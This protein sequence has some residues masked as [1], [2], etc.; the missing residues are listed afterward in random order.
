M[1]NFL[2]KIEKY[3][4]KIK[5]DGF[6]NATKKAFVKIYSDYLVKWDMRRQLYFL[7]NKKKI[8]E[9]L[10]IILKNNSFNRIIIWRSS[11]G[12][13]I[14]LFQRPQ[15]LAIELSKK[16]CLVFF[17]VTKLTDK[18][19]FY[20]KVDNNLYLVNF[21]I[22]K[23]SK[24]FHALIEKENISKYLFTASTCWDMSDKIV[25]NYVN[26]GY[27]FL[28]DYLDE[29]SPKLAGTDKLP[30]N[31]SKIYN[32]VIKNIDNCYVLCTADNLYNDIVS[33][34]KNNRNVLYVSNGVDYEHFT[35]IKKLPLSNDYQKML[36]NKK[37]IIGYYGALASWFDY[38]LIR[39][40]ALERPNYNIA[41]IGV[42]YDT[43]FDKQKINELPNVFYFGGKK[44]DELPYYAS[45]F[46]ICI[47]PFKI[48]EI[49][50]STNPIKIFEY[51]ALNKPIVSTKLTEC[52]K[53]QSVNIANNKK[54]FIELIDRY[55]INDDKKYKEKLLTDAKNNTWDSKAKCIIEG[56]SCFENNTPFSN[57][58]SMYKIFEKILLQNENIE[59][60]ENVL[61]KINSNKKTFIVTIN[62]EICMHAMKNMKYYDLIMGN[63]TLLIPDSVS[64]N[65]AIKKT[66]GKKIM[67]YAGIDL[68]V[69]LLTTLNREQKK[70]FLFGAKKEVVENTKKFIN[71]T[72]SN[73]NVIGCENGYVENYGKVI[74][75]IVKLKP[76]AVFVA[77]GVPKQELFID[78]VF[79]LVN[80]G[81]F[82]GVGG[83]FDVLSGHKKRAPLIFRKTKLEW[84]YR[85]IKEPKRI[86]KFYDNNIKL[87]INSKKGVYKK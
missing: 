54:E 79:G 16:G 18:V 63:D 43:E 87:V 84:L 45:K 64:M 34:R 85:I 29:L 77:L 48:N 35:K 4:S 83:S 73:I 3:F 6:F 47:L 65:Y 39:N 25:N 57:K 31:V 53:Y 80:K 21:D 68:M 70:I 61:R 51:M 8:E 40:L 75:S 58:R 12:W 27:K 14:P 24:L 13:N 62:S 7:Y 5:R 69:D 67:G 23:F 59:N 49:T 60:R 55:I 50:E 81:I 10:K 2:N 15:Q 86:R 33:K 32:Y 82:I 19:N 78:E 41:L 46:D 38:D 72:F 71:E 52:Q 37:K 44:Y 1:K 17:E 26:N 30:E 76:D 74:E 11:I 66:F 9:N 36:D 22:S 28:Y 20:K 42:K 56:L